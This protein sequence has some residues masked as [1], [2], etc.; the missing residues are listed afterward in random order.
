MGGGGEVLLDV[1]DDIDEN[2]EESL[3]L[4]KKTLSFDGEDIFNYPFP[5]NI[6]KSSIIKSNYKS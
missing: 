6:I 5:N 1:D 4:S 2:P 3:Q